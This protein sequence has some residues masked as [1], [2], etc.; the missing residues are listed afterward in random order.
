MSRLPCT[1][2]TS[3]CVGCIHLGDGSLLAAKP[4][5][6]CKGQ[7]WWQLIQC[8]NVQVNGTQQLKMLGPNKTDDIPLV[9]RL[10][11][12][13]KLSISW[14]V[15]NFLG[16]QDGDWFCLY[17]KYMSRSW[18]GLNISI[19]PHWIYKWWRGPEVHFEVEPSNRAHRGWYDLNSV[20]SNSSI[21]SLPESLHYSYLL[22]RVFVRL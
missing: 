17:G 9:L 13:F 7:G 8:G 5:D 6:G 14:F 11:R 22:S 4:T 21:C 2:G 20:L 1:D 18:M 10:R 19:I 16:R 12:V 15:R 3:G